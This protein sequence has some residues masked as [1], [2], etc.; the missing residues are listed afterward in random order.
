MVCNSCFQIVDQLFTWGFIIL[1]DAISNILLGIEVGGNTLEEEVDLVNTFSSG[2]G[3]LDVWQDWATKSVFVELN[4]DWFGIF[5]FILS[6][7]T[8]K[9][10]GDS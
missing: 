8:T 1:F 2:S 4:K 9:S 10:E 6:S 7:R 5:E 3:E